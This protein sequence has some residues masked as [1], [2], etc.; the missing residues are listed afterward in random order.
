VLKHVY[1]DRK[2]DI[3]LKCEFD[4]KVLLELVCETKGGTNID[5]LH[6]PHEA[7]KIR[8][9]QKAFT[10]L[11]MDYRIVTDTTADWWESEVE[12]GRLI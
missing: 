3:R 6:F 4:G 10:A 1:Q 11:G 12:Q 8:C 2:N 5:L 9:A 7:R